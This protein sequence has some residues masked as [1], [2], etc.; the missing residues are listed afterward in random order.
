MKMSAAERAKQFMPFSALKGL[1]EALREKERIVVEKAELSEES[2]ENIANTLKIIEKGTYVSVVYYS[3]GEYVSAEGI[4]TE[5]DKAFRKMTVI[6]T[7]IEFDNI[8][9][10]NVDF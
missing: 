6:K 3:D 5:F 4:V 2:A 1:D 9:T 8:Y 10:I 7:Q